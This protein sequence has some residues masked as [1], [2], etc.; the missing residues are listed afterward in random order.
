MVF[1]SDRRV[2]RAVRALSRR[3]S[4]P[5]AASRRA[6]WSPPGRA[7][8]DARRGR[9][10]HATGGSGRGCRSSYQEAPGGYVSGGY[11]ERKVNCFLRNRRSEVLTGDPLKRGGNSRGASTFEKDGPVPVKRAKD[12]IEI[13]S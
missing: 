9:G 4:A 10:G 13:S 6:R 3:D 1:Q 7:L 11:G 5:L 12:I 8:A 2:A